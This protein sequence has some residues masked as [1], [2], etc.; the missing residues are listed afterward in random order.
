M[1]YPHEGVRLFNR[2]G[3][4]LERVTG[5]SCVRL[6]LRVGSNLILDLAAYGLEGAATASQSLLSIAATFSKTFSLS[7]A[8]LRIMPPSSEAK[9]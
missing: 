2:D 3:Q 6:C 4:T 9:M 7:R 8:L 1:A 5:A